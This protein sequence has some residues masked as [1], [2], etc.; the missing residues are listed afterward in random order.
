M[1][2][3]SFPVSYK[4]K[5]TG[6]PTACYDLIQLAAMERSERRACVLLLLCL[7]PLCWRSVEGGYVP[8][9]SDRFAVFFNGKRL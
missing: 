9:Y 7:L 6:V 5:S 8:V 1:C 4:T 2:N 3:S